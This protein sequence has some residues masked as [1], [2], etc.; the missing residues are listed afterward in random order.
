VALE[1]ET[2]TEMLLRIAARSSEPQ[3][4]Y[5][6][7]ED[8]AL[9]LDPETLQLDLGSDPVAFAAK[10]LAI[11]RDLFKRQ[12]TR[13]LSP[14]RD[15]AVL[16]RSL[17]FALNDAARALGV[18][19]RQF[20][21]V[22]TLRD[23]PGSGRDPLAPVDAQVQ[24]QALD[25]MAGFVLSSDSLSLSPALQRRLAPDY[26]DWS[27]GPFQPPDYLLAQR[28]IGLQR[29]V[30]NFLMSDA[31]AVR[32]LDSA[33]KVDRP[34]QAFG[35]SEVHARLTKEVWAELDRV[36]T[37]A[38]LRRE[39]QR[40]H[41]NRLAVALLRPTPGGRADVRGLMR[42]QARALQARLDAAERRRGSLDAETRAHLV[43][44]ADTL[45]E[46]LRAPLV[47][48]GV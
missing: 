26:L 24:R 17:D 11:A 8:N 10:R 27:G 44:S 39:L 23:F 12:E 34:Q 22:R 7:D 6:T 20:G 33:T 4:A 38:P 21:G 16:R 5:G 40:D 48:S 31:L 18:L 3:L 29:A 45:R 35:L 1:T 25:L 19:A 13:E 47:R 9:G 2:E 46:A 36:G 30:L 14:Q 15:Y 28:L 37:I 32:L 43:D 42:Q 41:V